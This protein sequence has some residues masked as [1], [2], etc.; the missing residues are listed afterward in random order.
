MPACS[1][2]ISLRSTGLNVVPEPSRTQVR[3]APSTPKTNSAW[4]P[5]ML[6]PG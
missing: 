3:S 2:Q 6:H 4:S 1:F 5:R